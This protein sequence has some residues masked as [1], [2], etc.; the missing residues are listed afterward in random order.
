MVGYETLNLVILVRIQVRQPARMNIDN[1]N[2]IKKPSLFTSLLLSF[3]T[4]MLL[5]YPPQFFELQSDGLETIYLILV[6]ITGLAM[7]YSLIHLLVVVGVVS[8]PE[9]FYYKFY[10]TQPLILQKIVGYLILAML[11]VDR[12]YTLIV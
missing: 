11:I 6:I 1:L 3:D 5:K 7:V 10:P 9:N 4:F 2:G 12:I 8:D